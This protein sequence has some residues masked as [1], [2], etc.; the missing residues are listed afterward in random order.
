MQVAKQIECHIQQENLP[1]GTKLISERSMAQIYHVSRN[2]VRNALWVLSDKGL[3]VL[4][5]R[6]GAFVSAPQSKILENMR[7]L[8]V[9]NQNSFLESLEV[10]EVLESAFCTKVI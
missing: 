3:V 9:N 7:I 10:R 2:V 1:E 6:Q 4:M 8:L 5:A